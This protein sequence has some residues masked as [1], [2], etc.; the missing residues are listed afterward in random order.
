M[1]ASM[2]TRSTLNVGYSKLPSRTFLAFTPRAMMSTLQKTWQKCFPGSL[3]G[4]S[5][6]PAH[7]Y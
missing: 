3:Q 2:P 6:K 5:Q 7:F 4:C 1:G